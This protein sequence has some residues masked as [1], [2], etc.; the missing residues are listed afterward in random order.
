MSKRFF[1]TFSFL[2]CLSHLLFARQSETSVEWVCSR[3]PDRI[4]KL[5]QNLDITKNGLEKVSAAVD[6]NDMPAACN[7]LIEYYKKCDSGS[8][9]RKKLPQKNS[10]AIPQAQKIIN[11][12]ITSQTV[13]AKVPRLISGGFDWKFKGP[14][15]DKEWAWFLNRHYHLK[16]LLEV[17][18]QT[19]N[20]VYARRI[21]E[22]IRD[23]VTASPYPGIKSKTP[24]WRGLEAYWRI[25]HWS[26]I[27]Y[28]LQ[29]SNEFTL[30]ARILM[31][32]SIPE[33]AH[34]L[35]NF[36]AVGGNWITME[37]CGLGIA[38]ISWPE[39]KSS[40]EWLD[41]GIDKM[42]VQI[43]K[44]VYPDGA[45][46]EL[47]SHYHLASLRDGFQLF[48]DYLGHSQK[49]VPAEYNQHLEKMWNYLAYTIRP[50]GHGLLNN[51]SDR[52]FN[53]DIILQFAEKLEYSDWQWIASNGKS[54]KA[55]K[56]EPSIFFPWAGQLIMRNSYAADAQWA[57][58]DF[59]PLG[60]GGH[61]HHDKLHI[62]VAAFGRDIL[63]DS[64]RYAYRLSP[65][66]SYVVST[67][68]H[69][70][71]LIDGQGQKHCERETKTSMKDQ[72]IISKKYDY[73]RGIFDNGYIDIEG[74]VTH[75]RAVVYLRNNCW[76]VVDKIDT[77]RLRNIQTL[78]HWNPDCAVISD[79]NT[80]LSTDSG[81]GNLRIVPISD[82]N[83][84]LELIKGRKQP[85]QGWYSKEYNQF[86]PSTASVYSAKIEKTSTFAWL[87]IPAKGKVPFAKGK[88][89][90]VENNE[91]ELEI[92]PDGKKRIIIKIPLDNHSTVEI[93]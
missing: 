9:L 38:A 70:T 54:G 77:D 73:A 37:M 7:A 57:F 60:I 31:L 29:D 90:S 20:A 44:Q 21:D 6:K 87:L 40:S 72:G 39:F 4:T 25:R 82:M 71:I 10:T 1:V 93:K 84:K 69:N 23:W 55:P 53:K 78:W 66:R 74:Q 46:K 64:G 28:A 48:A 91:V 14:N 51:D 89:I 50:D 65:E 27:F 13:S 35:R 86:V 49:K 80:S 68:A 2:L 61:F 62:S 47:T 18:L 16:T 75:T 30:A 45:Q 81:K 15:D 43:S 8:W 56:A 32:S 42:A 67:A 11:D 19:G 26:L 52:D 92:M 24:Q 22:H 33:H 36:H 85:M 59:G 3:Y 41:Y 63:V 5:F 76:I 17:Y 79:Y 34:Y 88:I 58:F 83:W 12:I